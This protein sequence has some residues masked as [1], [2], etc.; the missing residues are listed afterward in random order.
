MTKSYFGKFFFSYNEIHQKTPVLSKNI[1]NP[2]KKIP[3]EFK[4]S[5]LMT[6]LFFS[7]TV[8]QSSDERQRSS[9]ALSGYTACKPLSGIGDYNPFLLR[10]KFEF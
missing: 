4:C 5:I 7:P 9:D 8:S 10:H 1:P 6:P 3:N 2:P